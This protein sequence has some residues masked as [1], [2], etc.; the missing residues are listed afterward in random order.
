MKIKVGVSNRHVHLCKEDLEKLFGVDYKLNIYKNLT[1]PGQFACC[2][3]V[4]IK[5]EKN[6]I[7][8][9]RV[10]GPIRN[11]TQVEISKTDAYNLGI[12]P[13]IR[14]SGNLKGSSGVTIV[15]PIGEIY[16]E[17]CCIIT[18]RHIHAT[19]EDLKKYNLDINKKYKVKVDGEKAGILENI[20]IKVDD[21]YVF[22]LH[23]D[24]DDANSHLIKNGDILDLID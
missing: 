19:N 8:N 11:Y 2:E 13:P 22:E 17:E 23:I 9:V 10:V 24:T 5:T 15:G 14:D 7:Q 1:Q 12:N 20:S 4:T 16:L 18:N 21:N 3:V 6:S